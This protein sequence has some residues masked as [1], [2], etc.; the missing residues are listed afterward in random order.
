[1][2]TRSRGPS[3]GF[4]WLNRG[5][6]A[7]FRYPKPLF[8]GAALVMLAALIPTFVVLP[9]QF[10]ALRAGTP[11]Q[12]T[13]FGWI[14]ASS[15]LISLLTIPLYAGYLQVVDAAERGLPARA[16]DVIKPYREGQALRLIGYGVLMLGIYFAL[17]AIVLAVTGGGIA[18]WYM[19]ALAAQASHQR[20]PMALPDGFGITLLLFVVLFI[21]MIGFYSISLG[22]IALRNRGVFSAIGDGFMGALK[23]VLPLLMLALALILIWIA[24]AICFGIVALLL[25]LIGKLGGPLLLF[26]LLVPLYIALVLIVFTAMFGVQYQLWRDVCGDD[27]VPGMAQPVAA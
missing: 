2:T 27:I 13:A 16:G 7:G 3:A 19:Q 12:P 15:T 9:M 1:M 26:V 22:Q 23:N 4:G 20:P 11:L 25:M 5:I 10:H 14:W 6:G 17:F 8:G 21:F 24:V 18:H